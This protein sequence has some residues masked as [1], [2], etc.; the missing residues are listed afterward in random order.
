MITYRNELGD[1]LTYSVDEFLS[2]EDLHASCW[3]GCS[4]DWPGCRMG[5]PLFTDL[6]YRILKAE[7]EYEKMSPYDPFSFMLNHYMSIN[8]FNCYMEE[9]DTLD[10]THWEIAVDVEKQLLEYLDQEPM[11][12]AEYDQEF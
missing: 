6:S 4:G 11:A 12:E 3:S 2:H 8:D 5:C 10:G 9:F 1:E 7:R